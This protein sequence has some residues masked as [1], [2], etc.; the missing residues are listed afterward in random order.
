M[1]GAPKGLVL[2]HSQ[3][4]LMYSY[5]YFQVSTNFF[6]LIQLVL[7]VIC[8][9]LV[10]LFY[11]WCFCLPGKLVSKTYLYSYLTDFPKNFFVFGSFTSNFHCTVFLGTAAKLGC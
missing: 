6:L 11:I 1:T 7:V 10:G 8:A 5:S 4:R 9:H 3:P 2:G